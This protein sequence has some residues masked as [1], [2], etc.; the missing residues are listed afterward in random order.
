MNVDSPKGGEPVL[1]MER[2]FDAPREQVWAA[3]TD[4]AQVKHWYGG[5]GFENPVCEMDVR[6]GGRWRHVMRTPDGAEF[7]AE[8]VFVEVQPPERLVWRTAGP[9]AG[10]GGPHDNVLTVTLTAA[11]RKTRW[12]L[13]VQFASE[14]DRRAAREIGFAEVLG[15]GCEKLAGLVE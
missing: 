10:R 2:E 13:V 4:P 7:P 11:G 1:V 9:A 12:R 3:L 6:P 5:H 15:Q 14:A 8:F